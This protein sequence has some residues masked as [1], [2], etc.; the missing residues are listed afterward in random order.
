MPIKLCQNCGLKVFVEEGQPIPVPFLCARCQAA[1][2]AA[3]TQHERAPTLTMQNRP[4]PVAI[5]PQ[6]AAPVAPPADGKSQLSCPACSASFSV[7]L[8]EQPARGKCPKCFQSLLVYPDGIVVVAKTS[9][10]GSGIHPPVAGASPSASR[11]NLQPVAPAAP[12]AS[13]PNLQPVAA[14]PAA[15]PQTRIVSASSLGR[16]T[17][18]KPNLQPV[19]AD[20]AAEP[21]TMDG[22]IDAPDAGSPTATNP[23][24]AASEPA[25]EGSA[26]AAP[27]DAAPEAAPVEAVE[28]AAPAK[29]PRYGRRLGAHAAEAAPLPGDSSAKFFF[30][31]AA[32]ALPI[33][34]GIA[35]YSL[36]G[37]PAVT[38]LLEK[39]GTPFKQGFAVMS[40]A[41]DK[42][43]APKKKVPASKKEEAA[44]ETPKSDAPKTGAP[45]SD[46]PPADAPKTDAP[47]TDA[48]KSETPPADAPKTD[49]PKTDAPK[50]ETPPADAPKTDAPKADAPKADAPAPAPDA[51]K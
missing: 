34:A 9:S 3:Q 12:S 33:A 13:R 11:P 4:R 51:T 37:N 42:A 32:V 25:P 20:P 1:M 27:V 28:A 5:A 48:P 2:R 26:E 15:R 43:P 30:T 23:A 49:A 50:S 7:R 47:K 31:V 29:G 21:V 24:V 6:Q 17:S 46:A 8:P 10:S 41:Q 44:P 39:A 14:A 36:R 19:A 35:L 22:P 18:S 38:D 16:P 45:K 40:S